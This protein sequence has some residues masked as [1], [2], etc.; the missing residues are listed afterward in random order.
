MLLKTGREIFPPCRF[1]AEYMGLFFFPL[2]FIFA[3]IIGCALFRL[4]EQFVHRGKLRTFQWAPSMISSDVLAQDADFPFQFLIFAAQLV[5]LQFRLGG[6]L[7]ILGQLAADVVGI[8][9]A[10]FI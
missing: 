7:Q 8:L 5:Q 9:L 1:L 3:V 2:V 6:I 4:E 10:F